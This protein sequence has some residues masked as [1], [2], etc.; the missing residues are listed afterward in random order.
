M[1]KV[2]LQCGFWILLK[3]LPEKGRLFCTDLPKRLFVR[4]QDVLKIVFSMGMVKKNVFV[5]NSEN[6]LLTLS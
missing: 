1:S 6:F 5:K 4:R 3:S 2:V